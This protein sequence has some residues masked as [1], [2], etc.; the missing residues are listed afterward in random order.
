MEKNHTTTSSWLYYITQA[1]KSSQDMLNSL[2]INNM[3]SIVQ[4][5]QHVIRIGAFTKQI[6]KK[7]I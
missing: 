5:H 2:R 7:N 4:D 1:K 6:L 3:S